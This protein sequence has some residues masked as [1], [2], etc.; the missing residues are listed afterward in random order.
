MY[1]KKQAKTLAFLKSKHKH[2]HDKIE[3]LQ[4]EKAPEEYIVPLKKEKLALKDEMERL[5]SV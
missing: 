4:A 3:V 5:R 1:D 2:L